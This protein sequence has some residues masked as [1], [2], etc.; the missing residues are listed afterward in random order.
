MYFSNELQEK[1]LYSSYMIH[2]L[3]NV[4]GGECQKDYE[5]HKGNKQKIQSLF[6]ENYA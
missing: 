5:R 6:Y 2:N 1:V 4:L 3:C